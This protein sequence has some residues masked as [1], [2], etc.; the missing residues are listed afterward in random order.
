MNHAK[1]EEDKFALT[2]A[3]LYF[4]SATSLGIAVLI[5]DVSILSLLMIYFY[6]FPDVYHQIGTTYRCQ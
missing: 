4:L 5:L 2:V 6:S 1:D 3:I